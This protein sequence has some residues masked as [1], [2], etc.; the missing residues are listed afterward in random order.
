[1]NKFL[2]IGIFTFVVFIFFKPFLFSNLH[3]IPADTII[4]LY[5]PFRDLYSS[6]Y[7]NGIPFKNFLITD[8]VRQHYPWRELALSIVKNLELPLWNPYNMAGAPLFANFQ[9]ATLYPFN[10]AFIFLPFSYAWSLLVLLQ[11]LLAC[12][13][14]YLYLS[15]LR[16]HKIASFTGAFA[17]AFSGFSIAWL[18]WN[19]ILHVALWLPLILLVKEY[20]LNKFS[21]K[22]ILIFIF[23]EVS[24][25][26]AGHLQTLFYTLIISNA[27]LLA[28]IIQIELVKGRSKLLKR[29]VFRYR[30]FLFIGV[31][32]LTI[33]AIQWF[34]TIQFIFLSA[35]DVDQNWQQAGWF[36][37]WQHLIQFVSPDFFGNPTTL[38]YWGVW[39]YA[40]F[41]GYIGI[42]PLIMALYALFFRRD[43]KT[44]FFG[45]LFFLSL[46]FSLPTP[47]AKLPYLLHIPFL[48]TVQPTRLLFVTDF[49]LAILAAF[50]ADY[51]LRLKNRQVL[52]PLGF[53]LLIFLGLWSFVL[54]SNTSI[55]SENILV[56]RRNLIFPTT[57][58]FAVA[59][60]LFFLLML[61][62]QYYRITIMLYAIMVGITVFDL[63]RF[64][65]KF[66]PFTNPA[67]LFPQTK[68]IE[69]LQKQQGLFRIMATDSRILP[70]N[71]SIIYR[72]QSIDGYDP[73]YLRRY[74]EIIAAMERGRPDITPPF[75]FNRIITPK[76]FESPIADFLGVKYVLS[77]SDISSPKLKK[78]FQEG[79]TRV[80]EN[81]N[82][83]PRVFFVE[84]VFY[85]GSKEQVIEMLLSKDVDI[86]KIAVVESTSS[87]MGNNKPQE[88]IGSFSDNFPVGKARITRYSENNVSIETEIEG[89][90]SGVLVLTDS[91]YPIWRAKIDGS[92]T[93]IRRVNYNFRGVSVSPGKHVI[94]FYATLL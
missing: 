58:F 75:G 83:L 87:S 8:P 18:E 56:S 69:F 22:L 29:I 46:I 44:L 39:N 13:F 34:P 3:P 37:P 68:T 1:M 19:T 72:L 32:V 47:F 54:F 92:E 79:Q 94:E 90:Y 43:K 12:I 30:P 78:V 31:I 41:I 67:Y 10:I 23:A 26:F 57:I 48:S 52:Y 50:G 38:N 65:T 17:F 81:K 80:Y 35:R 76:N 14:L 86:G 49:S 61:P 25:I 11:P 4:G 59:L 84:K 85:A 28:R 5:H 40:E 33:T 63:F 74:G 21:L 60:L 42:F 45:G 64:G 6:E 88:P 66:T 82:A 27:Y 62:K 91:F 24:A 70:P 71:F 55:P 93:V 15:Y 20:M 16:I 73:L 7:P 53:L 77:L 9:S 51:F 36:I 89:N 2:F